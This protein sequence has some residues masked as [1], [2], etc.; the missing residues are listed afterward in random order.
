MKVVLHICCGVC[1]AGA[2]HVLLSEGHEVTG[3]YYNPNIS[4][5]DEYTRRLEAASQAADRLGF[6]LI[7]G[8]YNTAD[9]N[10]ACAALAHEPEGG[11]RCEICYRVRLRQT[12]LFMQENGADAF[13]S[14]LTISPHKSALVINRIGHE[15]GGD[16]FLPRDFKKREGFKKAAELARDW[17]L[18]RQNYCGCEYSMKG[19]KR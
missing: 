10:Y 7:E 14:T 6:K 1:A 3:Y 5:P 16:K 12:F 2:A 17:G 11:R 19:E 4:P 13:T 15:T 9:W 18:Y 8:P